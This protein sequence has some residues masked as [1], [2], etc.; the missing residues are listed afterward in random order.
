M[1]DE[2]K[3]KKK[4]INRWLLLTLL[5][6]LCVIIDYRNRGKNKLSID[7]KD[8]LKKSKL[9]KISSKILKK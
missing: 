1:D 4:R 9:K 5:I 6:I 8:A 3:D 2:K 7:F